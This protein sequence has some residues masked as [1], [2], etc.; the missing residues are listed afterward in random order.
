MCYCRFYFDI[1]IM[2]YDKYLKA[3]YITTY[4]TVRLYSLYLKKKNL[5]N[6]NIWLLL[7]FSK[8]WRFP[9]SGTLPCPLWRT[10]PIVTRLRWPCWAVDR[11]A[12]A[13]PRFWPGWATPTSPSL[14]SMT[15]LED[16]GAHTIHDSDVFQATHK[17]VY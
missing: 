5:W 7:R 16:W 3:L 6:I 4:Y 14:K 2:E 8:P 11:R 10:S 13:V 9:K 17:K 12:S 1:K 15:T